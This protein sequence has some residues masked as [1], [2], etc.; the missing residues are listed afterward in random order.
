MGIQYFQKYRGICV[1]PKI[2]N[3][4]KLKQKVWTLFVIILVFYLVG[5]FGIFY[6][7]MR[8]QVEDYVM[9]NSHDTLQSINNSLASEIDK[10]NNFSRLLLTNSGILAYLKAPDENDNSVYLNARDSIYSVQN[11][12]PETCSV[13]VFR[14]DGNYLTVGTGVTTVDAELVKSK[15]WLKDIN[16]KKGGY[17][18]RLNGDGAFTSGYGENFMSLIR[19]I[20][21][22][23]TL[24]KKG[25]LVVNF[26]ISVLEKTYEG[27]GGGN[28]HFSYFD[29][30]GHVICQDVET[31]EFYN[32][33]IG[34]EN[35]GEK[36]DRRLFSVKIY[37]YQK[38]ERTGLTLVS[39]EEV[40]LLDNISKEYNYIFLY[41]TLATVI[42]FFSIQIFISVNI[43]APIK[44]MVN[45]MAYAKDGW[46]KRVS[47][48][49][50]HDE[51][52]L[53]KDSYNDMLLEINI[54]IEQLLLKEKEIRKSEVEIIQQQI[55]PHFLYNTLEMIGSMVLDEDREKVYD[56][57]ETLGSFYRQFLS[58]GSNRVSLKTEIL[59]TR[60]YL[61][62]QKLR[63]GDI[64]DA[65][66]IMDEECLSS[67]IPKLIL[68]PLVENSIYHGIRLKGE[69]GVIRVSLS[70]DE[71]YIYIEVYD[72][73]VGMNEQQLERIMN[74]SSKSF[75]FKK[76]I[77][78][79]QYY[80]NRNDV[81][82]VESV[83]GQFTKVTLK[84]L[85]Q[86]TVKL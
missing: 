5:M 51:I 22:I 78:R 59:I 69:K 31:K 68:Q 81:C 55:N 24:K 19:N 82:K 35:C 47:V 52:G 39:I 37:S 77:E 54:L 28:T 64:F 57:L 17:V 20:N 45:S 61:K 58:K 26:P 11:A 72:S 21:D 36:V 12:Y 80:E 33:E 79:L 83:E 60:D 6:F 75:G 14:N 50:S 63:Y 10:V 23:D 42:S 73:G 27:V 85:I 4:M 43:T 30:G 41:F 67:E 53:L 44:K 7:F 9:V 15:E 34:E 86:E 56:A 74:G 18:L 66:F 49:T 32:I 8:K 65:E 1:K 16:K 38:I 84:L 25:L 29:A 3:N 46:L 2:F 70:K 71:E 48:K 13:F 40:N 76:T 62:L